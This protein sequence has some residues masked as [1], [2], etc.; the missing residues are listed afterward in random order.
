MDTNVI[1]IFGKKKNFDTFLLISL[2]ILVISVSADYWHS[3]GSHDKRNE[4]RI[5][6]PWVFRSNCEIRDDR[7][8]SC[9]EIKRGRE[10]GTRLKDRRKEKDS[11]EER[12]NAGWNRGR[13]INTDGLHNRNASADDCAAKAIQWRCTN[14]ARYVPWMR[15]ETIVKTYLAHYASPRGVRQDLRGRKIKRH[16]I[17]FL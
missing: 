11:K 7:P 8:I 4:K 16:E 2:K 12:R 5:A 9:E 15:P 13:E 14:K 6:E 17:C 3:T 10:K 1:L